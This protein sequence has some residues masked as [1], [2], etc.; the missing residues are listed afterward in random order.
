MGRDDLLG[1]WGGR[2]WA[3][4]LEL[5]SEAIEYP[6]RLNYKWWSG[7]ELVEWSWWSEVIVLRVE[8]SQTGPNSHW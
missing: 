1:W 8:C 3:G 7:V 6:N 5:W 4:L 2:S